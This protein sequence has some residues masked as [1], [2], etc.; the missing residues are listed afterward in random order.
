MA[1]M[2][3]KYNPQEIEPKWQARWEADGQYTAEQDDTKPKYYFLEMFAYPSGDLHWGHI[4]NYTIGDAVAR[5]KAHTGYTVLHPTGFDAFGLPAENAAIKRGVHPRDW[6][7]RNIH[8][9]Q[10]QFRRMGYSYD[11][12]REF[13]TCDPTY[14]RWNQWFFIQLYKAG[15]AY[16]KKSAVNWCPEC[17]TALANEQVVNGTCERCE[18]GVV[19]RLMEQWYFRITQY[20]ERLLAGHATIDWPDDVVTMQKNWVGKS[21]GVEFAW[22][23]DG[24][25]DSLRV[26][27]TRPDTVFG[28]TFMVLAP[29]HPLVDAITTPEQRAA[30][31]TLRGEVAGMSEIDRASTELEKKG[32]FTGAYAVNPLS[33]EKAPIWIAN[34]VMMEYGTGA[35]M[36][37]PAHDERDFEFARKYDIPIRIVIAPAGA[38]LNPNAMTEAFEA[39][40]VMVNSGA[41]DG[42]PSDA[43]WTKIAEEMEARGIGN[44]TTN[45]R[46]RDWCISRQRYWGTPIPMVYCEA[47]GVQPVPE[48]QLPVLLPD[49]VTFTGA[50]ESPLTTSASF[51]NT[52]CP[53]CGGPAR[54]DSDTMDTFMDSSWYFLRYCSPTLDTAAFDPAEVKYWMPVD[55]YIGGREHATMHLIYARFFTMALHDMGL[56]DFDEPFTK[57]FNQGIVTAGGKKMSKRSGAVPPNDVVS[58]FGADSARLFILFMAPAGERAEWGVDP[59]TGKPYTVPP[60]IDGIWRFLNRVW[61]LTAAHVNGYAP[62]RAGRMGELTDAARRLRRKTHQTIKRVSGDIERFQ[63]N[64]AISA[65]MELTNEMSR[66]EADGVTPGDPAWSEAVEMG[67]RLLSPF[68]PHVACELWEALGQTAPLPN[69]PWPVFD[70]AVAAEE[71][72]EIPVQINGKLRD[73]LTVPVGTDAATLETLALQSEPV[74]RHLNGAAPRKVIVVPGKLVN[75]VA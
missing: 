22:A 25:P 29:E 14:Y 48:E 24:Y 10:G 63:F 16:K 38:D 18:T 46:L 2:N 19:K 74:Q 11:W 49:D 31:D 54:R 55:M 35:I 70:P 27:T 44:R 66:Y 40:G 45:Y 7:Y 73:K 72:L 51:M 5:Y 13:A 56:L 69:A 20:A 32:A 58:E 53:K 52:T 60:G 68:A 4:R 34:Y 33:G 36:A 50:G 64:T 67:T 41:Y 21:Q 57:L 65:L 62:D 59:E 1:R 30:V 12:A 28:V 15:L 23:I 3:E 37:V 42:L 17:Q 39:V 9:M 6:T 26:F 47:C 61:R 43:G 8:N 75:I 71:A